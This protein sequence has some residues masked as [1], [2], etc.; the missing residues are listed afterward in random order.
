LA[1]YLIRVR[2]DQG[3]HGYARY[4]VLGVLASS[5]DKALWAAAELL[6]VPASDLRTDLFKR[7]PGWKDNLNPESCFWIKSTKYG[8]RY[9][10]KFCGRD[11]LG[12]GG[13]SRNHRPDC[14]AKTP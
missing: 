5:H 4:P 13:A 7:P 12:I 10:C 11:N 6:G 2:D 9:L 1:K 3:L 8:Q 14:P